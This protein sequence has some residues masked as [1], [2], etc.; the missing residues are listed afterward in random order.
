MWIF[1]CLLSAITAGFA[2]LIMKKCSQNNNA[3]AIALIGMVT[4]YILYISLALTFTDVLKNF[5]I[6]TLFI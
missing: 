6:K 2:S 1:L 4:S 3:K 5:N